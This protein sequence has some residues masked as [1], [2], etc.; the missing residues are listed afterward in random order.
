[1]LREVETIEAQFR[2]EIDTAQRQQGEAEVR[3]KQL[4]RATYLTRI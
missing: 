1:V 3:A 4:P 2:A